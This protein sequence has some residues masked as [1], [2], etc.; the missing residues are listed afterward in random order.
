MEFTLL[1]P[2]YQDRLIQEIEGPYL[3]TFTKLRGATSIK[4]SCLRYN[5]SKQGLQTD[6]EP[7]PAPSRCLEDP[8]VVRVIGELLD[9][10]LVPLGSPGTSVILVIGPMPE[11]CTFQYLP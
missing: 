7:T 2:H 9:V 1:V 3:A 11:H 10:S 6:W 4:F 8:S 5:F